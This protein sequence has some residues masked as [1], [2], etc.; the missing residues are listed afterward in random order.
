MFISL[1][2]SKDF[3]IIL[4]DLFQVCK[5]CVL[6]DSCHFANQIARKDDSKTLKLGDVMRV[7][8][9]YALEALHPELSVPEEIKVSVSRLLNE[10]LKL[11]QTSSQG[12]QS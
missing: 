10:T 3:N 9:I 1:L 2:C 11:S 8:T 4:Y 6:K 7:I 5:K 12:D